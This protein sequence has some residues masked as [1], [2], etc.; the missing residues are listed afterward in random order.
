[1]NKIKLLVVQPFL[2]F[3]LLSGG[4]QAMFNGL[5]CLKDEVEL[6]LA[7][8]EC[9]SESNEN[10]VRKLIDLMEG[11]IQIFPYK[12]PDKE[13][14]SGGEKK[15][16]KKRNRFGCRVCRKIRRLLG[17]NPKVVAIQQ[18]CRSWVDE[19]S[20]L[21]E[22][23]ADFLNSIIDAKHIDMVQCEMLDTVLLPQKLDS[24]VKKVFVHHEIGT[25]VHELEIEKNKWN[26]KE[27]VPY[28]ENYREL[29]VK[30]LN[31][32]DGLISL[33]K[34]DAKKLH[35]MGVV[36]PIYDSF[37]VVDTKPIEDFKCHAGTTLAFVGPDCH[38]PNVDG[39]KWFLETCWNNLKATDETYELLI[40]GRWSNQ[41]QTVLQS[42]YEGIGFLGFVD[43][44]R[45]A[46]EN[47]IMIVPIRIGSGIRM[48]I[49]E[50][51]SLGIPFVSTSIG[52]EGIPVENGCHCFI[53]D[54]PKSF[55]D[56]ILRLKDENMRLLL[57]HRAYELV[58]NC[59]SME[60]L[61]NNRVNVY[62]QLLNM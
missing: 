6:Y 5:C 43:D 7:Y 34:S 26:R 1:M 14:L 46:L 51:A 50:A 54:T 59:Y 24:R 18:Y 40:V 17:V 37:A 44:L 36:V 15:D 61:R 62:R 60:A 33:S 10:N 22:G 53:A 3:P 28:L 35:D 55:V 58:R 21:D 16:S 11:K 48:K 41:M 9:A 23:F 20:H 52:A 42:Q 19:F 12:M 39:V 8:K 4:H 47:T 49:L 30:S 57:A 25:A 31:Q 38:F 56:S 27:I 29:E 2:P 32:F 45:R 13:I